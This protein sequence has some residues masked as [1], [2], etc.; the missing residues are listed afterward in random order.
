M[1]NSEDARLNPEWVDLITLLLND[2]TTTLTSRVID[3]AQAAASLGPTFLAGGRGFVVM[4]TLRADDS[5][6]PLA[7]LWQV[8]VGVARRFAV[9]GMCQMDGFRAAL[10]LLPAEDS[11]AGAVPAARAALEHFGAAGWILDPTISPATTIARYIVLL[12]DSAVRAAVMRN[13]T[14]Q[15][16]SIR[17]FADKQA[18]ILERAGFSLKNVDHSDPVRA[19]T[20]GQIERS[21]RLGAELGIESKQ[22]ET[23]ADDLY[24]LLCAWA[25]PTFVEQVL[26]DMRVPVQ[27]GIMHVPRPNFELSVLAAISTARLLR[28]VITMLLR[29]A[30]EPD[31][32]WSERSMVLLH[33]MGPAPRKGQS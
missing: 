13:G 18:L 12:K 27:G 19:T 10:E 33:Q 28:V 4:T 1:A 20:I 17:E 15:A 6:A 5:T 30:G 31:D 3:P 21:F 24:G 29:V 7:A 16:D 22:D 23:R 8:S 2:A 11:H 25:H 14:A 26:G 9:T 32:D